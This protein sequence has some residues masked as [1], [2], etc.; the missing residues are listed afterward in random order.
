MWGWEPPSVRALSWLASSSL[1]VAAKPLRMPDSNFWPIFPPLFSTSRILESISA[2]GASLR[3]MLAAE[4]EG[5][6]S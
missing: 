5:E 2:W 6:V 1:M 4:V 3:K